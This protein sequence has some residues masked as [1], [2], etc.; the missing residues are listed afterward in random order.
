[1]ADL[2]TLSNEISGLDNQ[3]G[4]E[5]ADRMNTMEPNHFSDP[6]YRLVKYILL[7]TMLFMIVVNIARYVLYE[8]AHSY[9]TTKYDEI[10]C[11]ECDY[12]M[13]AVYKEYCMNC[14]ADS[15]HLYLVENPRCTNCGEYYESGSTKF[16]NK[17]GAPVEQAHFRMDQVT[18]FDKFML[19]MAKHD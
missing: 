9:C 15:S 16:C 3:F 4:K 17:D 1:M 19:E 6:F 12:L 5:A 11:S 13:P 10:Q 7:G 14:G 2:K 18:W 8:S